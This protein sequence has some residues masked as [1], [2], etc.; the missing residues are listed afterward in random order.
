MEMDILDQVRSRSLCYYYGLLIMTLYSGPCAIIPMIIVAVVWP[1]DFHAPNA[2]SPPLRRLDFIGALL[3]LSGSVLLVFMLF[4]G[5]TRTY[6]WRSAAEIVTLTIAG[7]SWLGLVGWEWS[8]SRRP[9]IGGIVP[10]FPFRLMK[11]RIM[12]SGFM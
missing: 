2:S 6:S 7:C 3:M 10:H 5:A 1:R 4:Q 12:L 8:L 11:D 9:E